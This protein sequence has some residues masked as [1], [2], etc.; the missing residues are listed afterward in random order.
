MCSSAC[1]L[2]CRCLG[3]CQDCHLLS[4]LVSHLHGAFGALLR[5]LWQTC[6]HF[7]V[8]TSDWQRELPAELPALQSAVHQFHYFQLGAL[9]DRPQV[10]PAA[11]SV[12]GQ[13]SH[14]ASR[15]FILFPVVLLHPF[16][17]LHQNERGC[18][19]I[20]F[21]QDEIHVTRL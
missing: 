7:P 21:Q 9:K 18:V 15:Q 2:S 10:F 20:L 11:H 12:E 13:E 17:M 8:T 5:E 1:C 16:V 6:S 4:S 3:S 14:A 19:E